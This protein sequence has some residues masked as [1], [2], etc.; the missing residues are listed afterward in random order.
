MT[1]LTSG[2][3]MPIPKAI[4]ATITSASSIKNMSWCFALVLASSPA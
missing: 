3:S 4:V 1:N 2:L